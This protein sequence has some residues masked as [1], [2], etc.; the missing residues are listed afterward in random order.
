METTGFSKGCHHGSF[1]EEKEQEAKEQV[2][3]EET[4]EAKDDSSL[5]SNMDE[6]PLGDS[7]ERD[8]IFFEQEFTRRLNQI[9]TGLQCSKSS[10]NSP[11]KAWEAIFTNCILDKIVTYTNEYGEAMVS[12]WMKVTRSNLMNFI[13]ILFLA[14]VEKEKI[15]QAV[16]F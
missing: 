15:N 16:G 2:N 9:Q 7:W 11:G 3:L 6:E 4:N 1:E 8:T 12:R 10:V 13:S 5:S 14:S